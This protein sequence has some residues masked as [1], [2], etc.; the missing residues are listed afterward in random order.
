MIKLLIFVILILVL[1]FIYRLCNK[2]NFHE[3][4]KA[5]SNQPEVLQNCASCSYC[6]FKPN[7][8]SKE[9][10][11]SRCLQQHTQTDDF[12]PTNSGCKDHSDLAISSGCNVAINHYIQNIKNL[13]AI[14]DKSE[15]ISCK[16]R[17]LIDTNESSLE[18]NSYNSWINS[19]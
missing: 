19:F 17:Y 1:V 2:E 6:D 14:N 9:Y 10:I 4:T 12:K 15:N 5:A 18:K 16:C 11:I 7:P 3:K 8:E 13:K